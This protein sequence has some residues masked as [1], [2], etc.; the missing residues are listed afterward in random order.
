MLNSQLPKA[1]TGQRRLTHH[2]AFVLALLVASVA[3]VR[4]VP[5]AEI[6]GIHFQEKY[7]TGGQVLQLHCVGLLRYKILFKGYVELALNG[8]RKGIIEGA[9]FAAKYFAI[10][11]EPQPLDSSLK[12]QL[13]S[14]S[15][16]SA[17]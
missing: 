10:W 3:I 6:E 8:V 17:S 1:Q 9:D 12:D 2:F 15:P 4:S 5:A 14:C 16:S 13:L 11:L 7:D